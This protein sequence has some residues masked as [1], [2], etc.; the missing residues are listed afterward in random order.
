[1]RILSCFVVS[2]ALSASAFAGDYSEAVTFNMAVSAGAA[3]CLPNANATVRITPNGPNQ[4]MEVSVRGLRPNTTYTVFVLQLPKAPF[5]V[6]WYQGDIE[7]NAVGSGRSRFTGIFSDETFAHAQGSG[8]APVLHTGAFPDASAN[9]PFAPVHMFH[10]GIWFD[11][12]ADASAAGCPATN[13]PFNGDHTA[14]LQVLNTGGFP[15]DQGPLRQVN[16]PPSK[17]RGRSKD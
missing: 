15:N 16:F 6:A 7:T 12:P 8:A 11:S 9:P 13:T 17:P 3:T 10:V 2:L 1:M 5:G 14:G 4:E